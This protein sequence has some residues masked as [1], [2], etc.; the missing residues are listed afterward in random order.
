MSIASVLIANRGEIAIR[1]AATLRRMGIRSVGIHTYADSNSPHLEHVDVAVSVGSS[2][3]DIDGVIAAARESG[4]DAIHPGYGF[5]AENEEFARACTAAGLIFIGPDAD[6][7][8]AMGGKIAAREAAERAG[9]PV[10]PGAAG[11]DE[12]LLAAAATVGFP[13]LIKPSAGGGG[14]GLH[15]AHDL[16]QMRELLPVARREAISSFGDGALLIEH[17]LARPRHIE[18]QV[19]GDAFGDV[20]HLGEREC[21]LQR[22]HQKVIEETPSPML[23][24]SM[25]QRM[26]TAAIALAKAIGYRSAGTV[27]FL[28]DAA[29]PQKFHFIEMN[30]RLQVEHRVT[31]QIYGLD[32]VELQVQIAAGQRLG[33]LIPDPKPHGHSIQA[34]VYAEDPVNGFLPTGGPVLLFCAASN[35]LTDTAITTGSHV[36]SA[37]DPMLA[38]V[39]VHADTR[40]EAIASLNTALGET[41]IFG[42]RTNVDYLR[43][44]LLEPDFRGGV[45]D[46]G[47]IPAHPPHQ[48]QPS[49]A[50]LAAYAQA[51]SVGDGWRLNAPARTEFVGYF[52]DQRVTA[53]LASEGSDLLT[54]AD[55]EGV[56]VHDPVSGS[57]HILRRNPMARSGPIGSEIAM[58]P[59]PGVV[60]SVPVVVGDQVSEGDPLVILEAMKME[61]VLRAA[62]AGV[63]DQV[64]VEP[65]QKVGARRKLVQVVAHA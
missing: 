39:I 44:L 4:A 52:D 47:F 38:K 26:G 5:L 25:R 35:A 53:A 59:M 20:I 65:G 1:I 28:I 14:K 31:E 10:I 13:L 19:F 34:R 58:A 37:Y 64:W 42:L 15:I 54:L 6:A 60:I 51:L 21:T 46:T 62:H 7:I 43:D 3:L 48:H 49:A 63:V 2:Y 61:H 56:W 23:D 8:A 41:V 57:I 29:D 18:F 9:V 30:T 24:E 40:D 32:L 22:R 33:E 11:D 16:E 55:D 27:E 12:E 36:S 50:A 45:F 17:Y